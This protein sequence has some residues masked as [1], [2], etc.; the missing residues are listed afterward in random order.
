MW[1]KYTNVYPVC[2]NVELNTQTNNNVK[3]YKFESISK[4]YTQTHTSEIVYLCV[5]FAPS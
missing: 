5:T 4:K 1:I 3:K 2:V